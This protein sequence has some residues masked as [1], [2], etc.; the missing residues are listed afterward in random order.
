M[1]AKAKA[2]DVLISIAASHGFEP[3]ARAGIQTIAD[4]LLT[5]PSGYVDGTKL[6]TK[7]NDL[8]SSFAKNEP[9]ALAE[10]VV[11]DIA[12]YDKDKKLISNPKYRFTKN[13]KRLE[14]LCRDAVGTNFSISVFGSIW[15]WK[16]VEPDTTVRVVAKSARQFRD[17]IYLDATPCNGRMLDCLGHIAPLYAG[18]PGSVKGERLTECVDHAVSIAT[19]IPAVWVT[20]RDQVLAQAHCSEEELLAVS[21]TSAS[22]LAVILRALHRP[23]TYEEGQLAREAIIRVAAAAVRSRSQYFFAQRKPSEQSVIPGLRASVANV[24][25]ELKHSHGVE[26]TQNQLHCVTALSQAM[27]QPVPSAHMLNGDVGTGKTLTFLVPAV[28]AFRRSKKVVIIAPT[29]LLA[30]Q[31]TLEMVNRFP[32]T[33]VARIEA[34]G[35]LPTDPAVLIGT[36]GITSVCLKARFI[37]D[38][39]VID[40]QHKMAAPIREAL[41]GNHTHVLEASATPI[42]RSMAIV[43]HAGMTQLILSECPVKKEVHT[44]AL[45]GSQSREELSI[46]ISR[47]LKS[48]QKV[49]FIYPAVEG[50]SDGSDIDDVQKQEQSTVIH[51]FNRMNAKW[52]GKV[53][54]LYGNM[55][56]EDKRSEIAAMKNGEKNVLVA[57]SLIEVGID[58]PE[59]TVLAVVNAEHFG[60][61]QLHQFRGRV[62]RKGGVGHFM[63]FVDKPI[64]EVEKKTVERLAAMEAI[65]DGFRLAEVDLQQRGFGD[66]LGDQQ[67]GRAHMIFKGI[68]LS[69]R[70]FLNLSVKDDDGAKV[71]LEPLPEAGTPEEID[72]RSGQMAL[73]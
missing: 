45:Y 15:D 73:I 70:D 23:K 71:I 40:E 68:N 58:I 26:L 57:S 28:A 59:L 60:L 41:V 63:M 32:G 67:T 49:S 72:E 66:T 3:I 38:L 14:V 55:G 19:E 46:T 27:E 6:H 65:S 62:A 2:D 39:L 12:A 18:I 16:E 21:N 20:A 17:K 69:P 51:A 13:T 5:V 7:L 29:G 33:P 35:K 47:A 37:P 8:L 1:T 64:E 48:G 53:A 52:P 31:L 43:M 24:I 36:P 54:R 11:S 10:F 30:D 4:A 9:L 42:P 22:N 34:G 25:A 61:S 56:E 50:K 44:K